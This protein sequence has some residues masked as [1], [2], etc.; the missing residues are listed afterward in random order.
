MIDPFA[1]IFAIATALLAFVANPARAIDN[2]E[3]MAP[4]CARRRL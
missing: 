1:R 2:I 3:I 4:G